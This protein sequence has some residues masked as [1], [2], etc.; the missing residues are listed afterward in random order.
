MLGLMGI[1]GRIL[2]G[3]GKGVVGWWEIGRH[4]CEDFERRYWEVW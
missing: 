2:G 4:G 1:K 3:C